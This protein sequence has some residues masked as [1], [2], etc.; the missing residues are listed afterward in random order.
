MASDQVRDPVYKY[1]QERCDRILDM[2][3]LCRLRISPGLDRKNS[4]DVLSEREDRECDGNRMVSLNGPLPEGGIDVLVEKTGEEHDQEEVVGAGQYTS[5]GNDGVQESSVQSEA[6]STADV[7]N[8]RSG[9]V[10]EELCEGRIDGEGSDDGVEG[11]GYFILAGEETHIL[12]LKESDG[13]QE[14][15]RN[16][17]DKEFL[18]EEDWISGK[19]LDGGN[20]EF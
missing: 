1:I 19:Q 17:D 14:V 5:T 12:G 13:T 6:K 10:S 18:T 11:A 3:D 4:G 7:Y 2:L 9:T 16:I 8:V 20:G 15:E